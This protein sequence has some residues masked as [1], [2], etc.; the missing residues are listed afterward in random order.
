MEAIFWGVVLRIIQSTL[1]ASPFIFTGLCITGVLHRLMGHQHT[2]RLFGSNTAS[3]LIQSWLIGMILPGCSLG[4]IPIV[5][6][7]RRSGIAIGTIFAF[8]LSSPLFDPL[9]LLYGLTLSKPMAILIFATC[10]LVVVT[11]SGSFFDWL[12]PNTE[13][14]VEEPP[15]TPHGI[16]R[17]FSILV[18]MARESVSDSA[19]FI[20]CGLVGVGLLTIALPPGYL[21]S[22]MEHDNPL[23]PIVMTAVAIPVYATPMMAMAQIGSMFQHGNSIGA[24]FILLVF[25]AGM[26]LGL[27]CWMAVHYG[28]KKTTIWMS[29]MIGVVLA[30]S[31]GIERP[32]YPHDIE[33]A[34]H[35]HAFDSYCQ[36]FRSD[37]RL[38]E[39]YLPEIGRRVR[40]ETQPHEIVGAAFLLSL[41]TM[42]AGLRW[43]DPHGRIENWLNQAAKARAGSAQWDLIVP[44]EALAGIAFLAILA[45]SVAG[46]FAYY[47]NTD[48]SLEELKLSNIEVLSAA[49]RND[50]KHALHWIPISEDWLR[51]L[52]VGT[53]LRTWTLSDYQRMKAKVCR[54]KLERLEHLMEDSNSAEA[55][56]KRQITEMSH[57]FARLRDA[58]S[59]T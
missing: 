33:P 1:Q 8:A 2:K 22:A 47:P 46:C 44:R 6:Q 3:S 35:T 36:P 42:G 39:G 21:Q 53:Y 50:P 58:F 45:G 18:V 38:V 43:L 57:A 28:A 56:R 52:Q 11:V 19:V 12:Y 9:S 25:G 32:L 14:T 59:E 26:N 54:D 40:M 48:E 37:A 10:S 24:A 7:L 5:K 31:Y 15:P 30:L 20:G 16:K 29:I 55:L 4:V 13:V 49:L 34:N 41:M 27:L 17:L 51:R 23:S